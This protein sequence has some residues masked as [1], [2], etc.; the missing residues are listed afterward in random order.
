MA[1]TGLPPSNDKPVLLQP[2]PM[3]QTDNG[4]ADMWGT[5][6]GAANRASDSFMTLAA[7]AEHASK[8]K[9]LTDLDLAARDKR[10]ELFNQH[11]EDPAGF[12]AAWKGYTDGVL[13]GVDLRYADFA[14]QKLEENRLSVIDNIE[15][16]KFQKDKRLATDSVNARLEASVTDLTGAA[17]RGGVN[18]PEFQSAS[19]VARATLADAVDAGLMAP[20]AAAI[21]F[22]TLMQKAQGEAIVG[23][24]RTLYDQHGVE[25]A[26]KELERV[27]K[28]LKLDPAEMERVRN[29]AEAEIRQWETLRRTD[30]SEARADAQNLHTS[31]QQGVA[32]PSATVEETANRLAAAKGWRE[33]AQLRA[34]AAR[35]DQLQDIAR[36]PL[37]QMTKRVADL[38]A[39]TTTAPVSDL[40][41]LAAAVKGR[42][43]G[44]RQFGKDGQPLTS[45]AGA[46]GVMQ[47]MPGTG[48]EAAAAA[49]L[50]WDETRYRN[51]AA[52]NEALGKA[53]LGKML[54]RFDGNRTLALAAYNA[55][56]GAVD[57]WLGKIG[58]PRAGKIT[59]EQFAAAIPFKETRDYVNAITS[60]VGG[61]AAPGTD[62]KL[63]GGVQRILAAKANEEWKGVAKALDQGIQP[64]ASTLSNLLTAAGRAGDHDLLEEIATRLDRTQIVTAASKQPLAAQ[65]ALRTSLEQE[66]STAGLSPGRAALLVD[67]RK[68]EED[69]RTRVKTDPLGL[70]VDRGL[71]PSLAPVDWAKP[72]AAAAALKDRQHA[73]VAT[74]THYGTDAVPVLR[75]DELNSLKASWDGGD[76]GTRA[77]IV[78]TLARS[79]DGKHLT[80]TLEKVAGD[81]P[82]FAAAGKIYQEAGPELGLSIVRGQSYIDA[83][84]K[85]LPPEKEM[86]RDV[87]DYLGSAAPGALTRAGIYQTTLARYADLSAAAKDFGGIYDSSRLLQAVKDVT[88]GVVKW[89]GSSWSVSNR[90][91]IPPKPGMSESDFHKMMDG[92]TDADLA[93][94]TTGS[95]TPIKASDFK[96]LASLHD[97]GPGRYLVEIGGGFARGAD[98][99]PFVLNLNGRDVPAPPTPVSSSQAQAAA[100][101]PPSGPPAAYATGGAAAAYGA[102]G[103]APIART[104]PVGSM[105]EALQELEDRGI[106]GRIG[107]GAFL[108]M[109]M[110]PDPPPNPGKAWPNE[111]R[112]PPKKRK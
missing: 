54:D 22:D 97:A 16:A 25:G 29:R 57:G 103:G 79:L 80:A 8:L 46:I 86:R 20:D 31:F 95:G 98:G 90:Q 99:Q 11:R 21:R 105:S 45:K 111:Q 109:G 74:A 41:T 27:T 106:A 55:G 15:T 34:A 13:G 78:G 89:G 77:R 36:L 49:G 83:D 17:Y 30:L 53:Y 85:I 3:V 5:V 92:I 70:A 2:S 18:T 93:G 101:T 14:R 39:A 42:E 44:G 72:D 81:N 73:A 87:N 26:F 19:R 40:D 6:A 52:Y 60:K 75:P 63:L 61:F 58:D 71:L 104:G 68:L 91:I 110:P 62:P 66:A 7:Q 24:V 23:H 65:D 28:E 112:H 12:N 96:R 50:P 35:F 37:D 43:S 51:D 32:V 100:Y 107:S 84:K 108:Q 33:A 59:D 76:S 69:T 4:A 38:R 82:V 10:I 67:L 56:P 47:V 64:P 1:G 48:P 102:E 9:Y 88:G 94:A